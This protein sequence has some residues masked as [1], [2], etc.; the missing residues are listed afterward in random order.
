M[1]QQQRVKLT[2]TTTFDMEREEIKR[3]Y[4]SLSLFQYRYLRFPNYNEETLLRQL[5]R[6]FKRFHAE[7]QIQNERDPNNHII[8]RVMAF[9]EAHHRHLK[10]LTAQYNAK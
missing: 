8:N 4:T 3:L 6:D 2:T 10:E 9:F 7:M 1:E 5:E